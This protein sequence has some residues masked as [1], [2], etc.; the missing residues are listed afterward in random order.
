VPD[1][2]ET[3]RPYILGKVSP[4]ENYRSVMRKGILFGGKRDTLD[5][6]SELVIHAD[7]MVVNNKE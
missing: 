3:R 1:Q 2:V 5:P 7:S 4:G 6:V